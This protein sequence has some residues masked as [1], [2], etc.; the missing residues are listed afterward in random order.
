MA[1]K[2]LQDIKDID[3]FPV[4]EASFHDN[5]N[6]AGDLAEAPILIDHQNNLIVFKLQDGPVKE[7]GVNGCQV[8]TIIAAAQ[9]ILEGLDSKFP[10][11][12]NKEAIDELKGARLWLRVRRGDREARSVEGRSLA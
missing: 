12:E 6:L 8:D 2:T 1:L 3:G 9:T 7:A 5:H 10:C 11:R 4:A